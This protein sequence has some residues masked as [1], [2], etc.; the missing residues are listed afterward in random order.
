MIRQGAT[1]A[2]PLDVLLVDDN[3]DDRALVRRALRKNFPRIEVKEVGTRAGFQDCLSEDSMTVVITDFQLRWGDGLE[4]LH[5]VRARWPECAVIMFTDTGSEEIAA[6]AMKN[7]LDDYMVKTPHQAERL[8]VAIRQALEH[9]AQRRRAQAAEA[10]LRKLF[11][12]LPA[13][14]YRVTL[15][16]RVLYANETLAGILG[17]ESADDLV[18]TDISG[19]VLHPEGAETRRARKG[20]GVVTSIVPLRR[21]DGRTVWVR[22]SGRLVHDVDDTPLYYEGVI[23]DVTKVHEAQLEI[24]RQSR[25]VELLQAVTATAN[26]YATLEDALEPALR[27]LRDALDWP[28][29]HVYR[30]EESVLH[31]TPIWASD[32][33]GRFEEF[34]ERTERTRFAEGEGLPGRALAERA[35]VWMGNLAQ[36]PSFVRLAPDD[37]TSFTAGVAVPVVLDGEVLAVLEFFQTEPG[38]RDAALLDVLDKVGVQLARVAERERAA[39]ERQQIESAVQQS[40]RLEA[41]GRLAGGVAHDF[42]NL[43]TVIQSQTEFLLTDLPTDSPLREE[44]DA[45]RMAADRAAGLTSQLL[46]FGRKQALETK[47]VDL[48]EAV[49]DVVRLLKRIIGE[50][51]EIVTELS[52]DLPPIEVDATQLEQVLV[53]L[54]VNARH[55]MPDGGTFA[56]ATAMDVVEEGELPD[57]APGRYVCLR[58]ADTG[59]GMDRET[60]ARIFEPFF[61]TKSE[62][63]GTGL[64]LAMAH[65]LLKQVGGSINVESEPGE[66]ATFFLRFPPSDKE[67]AKGTG[68]GDDRASTERPTSGRVLVVE[69][70]PSV[71]AMIRKGLERSGFTVRTVPDA[72]AGLEALEEAPG[73]DLLLTDLLLPG[74]T[75]TELAR[76]VRSAH[77]DLRVVLMSGYT[78][79]T[80]KRGGD[81]LPPGVKFIEKPFTVRDLVRAAQDALAAE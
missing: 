61:S 19:I 41:I 34:R 17:Y 47:V 75:G 81:G 1:M 57:L 9:R 45:I 56:L 3:A 5:Q 2:S 39:R 54:A 30:L 58:V 51:I 32:G 36:D 80:I 59:V 79:G 76:T 6:R 42:N 13:G 67:L 27:L 18:G 16:E 50:D 43:L 37:D 48:N 71:R 70:E 33:S 53:N 73:Y 28:L 31:P 22:D 21:P 69:D 49:T 77:P 46:A 29:A 74:M 63:E 24:E 35:S 23:Q 8:P 10:H 68:A 25:F 52:G 38:A 64:G 4:V 78:D 62:D 7:G 55:A 66:G 72:E 14:V 15:D 11:D 26:E 20:D 12:R 40:Q 65:G 44:V 60:R